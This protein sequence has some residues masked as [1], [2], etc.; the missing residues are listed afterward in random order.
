MGNN[1]P[2]CGW[3]SNNNFLEDFMKRVNTVFICL[4]SVFAVAFF[5]GCDNGQGSGDNGQGA[6]GTITVTVGAGDKFYY[7]LVTGKEV[8]GDSVK[9]TGWDIGFQRP[10]TIL[11][12]SGDTATELNSGGKGTVWY[13]E[14][15]DFEAV[16]RADA[17]TGGDT[18]LQ[19]Y[20]T[21]KKRWLYSM[22][23][24]QYNTFNV[25]N[26]AGYQ[27][28]DGSSE[29]DDSKKTGSAFRTLL[30]DKKQ[31]YRSGGGGGGGY[32]VT[33]VV[34]IIRHGDGVHHSKIQVTQYEYAATPT[35]T[36]VVK[37]KSLD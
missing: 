37:Y 20:F 6:E 24:N 11:T 33:N 16:V 5:A 4:L 1:H 28:G 18:E 27:D 3:F 25:I 14:K 29:W 13:T 15:T 34:Y 30:Y 12:N 36:Y 2:L 8:T 10:R 7:S 9:T 23:A 22:K 17:V 32:P 26:Y 35:D 21:D 19:P 31:F